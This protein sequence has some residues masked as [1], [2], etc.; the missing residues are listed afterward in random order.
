MG[1]GAPAG[2]A[3]G[4]LVMKAAANRHLSTAVEAGL[5]KDAHLCSHPCRKV[6]CGS[7]Y[8]LGCLHAW[9]CSPACKRFLCP[10]ASASAQFTTTVAG[11]TQYRA[12]PGF[13]A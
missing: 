11:S 12:S 13:C 9:G 1:V 5:I 10:T 6:G 7:C 3:E 8:R 4:V 2:R